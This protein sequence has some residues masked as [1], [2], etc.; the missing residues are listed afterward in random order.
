MAEITRINL[1]SALWGMAR[2]LILLSVIMAYGLG[3][4]IAYG[5]NYPL[6]LP[7][8]LWGLAALVFLSASIH[9][10][11]EYAD[12]ETDTL[13]RKTLFSGGSGV[14]PGG[15]VGRRLALRAAW[16]ALL[17]GL[18]LALIAVSQGILAPITLPLLIVGA[19]L[20]WM[21][22]LPPLRLDWNGLGEVDNAILGAM[23]LPLYGYVVVTGA[24]NISV[25]LA[26]IPFALIDFLNLLGVTWADR[27]ADRQVGKYTLATRY[28]AVVMSRLYWLVAVIYVPLVL[29]LHERVLPAPVTI[30]SL[31]IVPPLIVSAVQYTK[32]NNPTL[33][34]LAMVALNI[35]QMVG[36]VIA[37]G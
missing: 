16:V 18:F 5:M 24:V 17:L 2:P 4:A 6:Q 35:F 37:R 31:L 10:A 28:P 32:T 30:A 22:S 25:V 19:F 8:L 27:A 21:Y 20:G 26:C 12:F 29:V 13:T 34:V 7:P 33:P 1:P 3:V 36:W 14:L 23:L 15:G 9:Y 11:N